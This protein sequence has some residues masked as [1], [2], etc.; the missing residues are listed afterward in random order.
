[1]VVDASLVERIEAL[2]RSEFR[3][4]VNPTRRATLAIG[5]LVL[6]WGQ[7]DSSVGSMIQWMKGKPKALGLLGVSHQYPRGHRGQLKLLRKLF[8]ACSD[9]HTRLT[10]LDTLLER[11]SRYTQ[12]RDDL[13]HGAIGLD[14]RAGNNSGLGIIC[15]PY[16]NPRKKDDPARLDIVTHALTE[17]FEAADRLND[18][19]RS[20]ENLI[21][22]MLAD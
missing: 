19:C 12:I 4:T 8:E 6:H 11:I 13:V 2:T 3:A 10:E 14:N 21:C 18:D 15:A 5:A 16:R 22:L 20:L 7:F 1:M 17:I 9:D